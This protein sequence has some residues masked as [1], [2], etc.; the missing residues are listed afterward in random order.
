MVVISVRRSCL[1]TRRDCH[2][3]STD[4]VSL[5]T[6]GLRVVSTSRC[7][8]GLFC[9]ISGTSKALANGYSAIYHSFHAYYRASSN[10]PFKCTIGTHLRQRYDP[11]TTCRGLPVHEINVVIDE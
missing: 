10:L 5:P 9:H 7:R 2:H 1:D 3:R 4:A 8:P 6:T 11:Q